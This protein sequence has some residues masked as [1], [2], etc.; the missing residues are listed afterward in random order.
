MARIEKTVFI[1]YRRTNLPWALAIFQ[2]LSRHGYDVFFDYTG[3]AQ[4]D[5]ES[6]ILG[7]I[8]ARAHF[9]VLLTPSALEHIHEPGDWLRHEIETALETRRNIVP[10]VLEGFDFSSAA[11]QLTGKLAELKKYNAL[12]VTA[13]YFMEAMDRLRNRFLNVPLEGVLHP[14]SQLTTEPARKQQKSAETALPMRGLEWR[15]AVEQV[16]PKEFIKKVVLDTTEQQA[17]A[18]KAQPVKFYS[19]FIS[20]STKDQKFASRLYEDLQ[21][22]GVQC[23]FAEHDMQGGKKIQ[24]QIDHAISI[25]DRL[26]LILSESSIQS[27]WVKN[28]IAKAQKREHQEKRRVLF[29]IGL[30]AFERL[31]KWEYIDPDT[32][33]DIAKQIREYFIPDFSQWDQGEEFYKETFEKL[34][35]ALVQ[36]A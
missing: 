9:L 6:V 28:E 21:N 10:L 16:V 11:N 22:K 5:F 23:W 25:H 35:R 17:F 26:L 30:V 12:E 1:S 19:C 3:V 7:N 14:A 36:T 20:Y 8:K 27:N 13:S 31:L 2:N 24:E 29:P 4:G 34:V 18:G 15:S 32:G 33:A